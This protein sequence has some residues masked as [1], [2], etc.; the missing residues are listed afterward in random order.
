MSK[1]TRGLLIAGGLIVLSAGPL[2]AAQQN[3]VAQRLAGYRELGA[4]FK[5]IND[6]LRSGTPQATVIQ[7]SARQ[8]R[9]VSRMQY[10]WFP[11]G[12]GPKPGVKTGAKAEIWSQAAQFKAAQDAFAVEANAFQKLAAAGNIAGMK[13]QSRKLGATCAACHRTF[14]VETR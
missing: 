8:I 3:I 12:S 1:L 2:M 11:A 14:R 5:N 10:N 6:E 9:D 13:A 4:A 7:L